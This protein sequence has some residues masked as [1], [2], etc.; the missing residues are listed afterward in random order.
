V[1]VSIFST[2]FG[3]KY[4]YSEKNSAKY[5][6]LR[7]KSTCYTCQIL[8]RV[9]SIDFRK[10]LKYE[11]PW[12]SVQRDSMCPMGDWWTDG[13]TKGW[14]DGKRDMTKPTVPFRNFMNAPK[15]EREWISGKF[16]L[17]WIPAAGVQSL[18]SFPGISMTARTTKIVHSNK[19]FE[20]T[21]LSLY[22]NC[23]LNNTANS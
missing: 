10:P 2:A 14:T 21:N 18:Q 12:K 4:C 5:Y 13:W 20:K 3:L 17:N 23:I 6:Y 15:N 8:I 9:F 1:C 19:S 16:N 22:K 7:V 11:I